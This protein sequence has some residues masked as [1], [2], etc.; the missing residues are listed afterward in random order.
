MAMTKDVYEEEFNVSHVPELPP[1][2]NLNIP[3]HPSEYEPLISLNALIGFSAPQKIKLIVYIKYHKFIILVD[4]RNTHN[5]IHHCLSQE[6]N[7]YICLVNS[8]QI[9]M[10]NGGSVSTL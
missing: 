3:S 7:C 1:P 2:T 10:S 4:S 5:F 8:F 9:L 6:L